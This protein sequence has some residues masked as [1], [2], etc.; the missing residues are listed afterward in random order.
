MNHGV[1]G[2]AFQSDWACQPLEVLALGVGLA[3]HPRL[4]VVSLGNDFEIEPSVGRDARGRDADDF[5]RLAIDAARAI[6]QSPIEDLCLQH[7]VFR[8][9][10]RPEQD[11]TVASVADLYAS[12]EVKIAVGLLFGCYVV[13]LA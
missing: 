10:G 1:N 6:F 5:G 13:E 2:R 9:E 8:T 11:P 7:S 12:P 3:V 4:D